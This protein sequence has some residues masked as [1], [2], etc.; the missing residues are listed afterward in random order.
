MQRMRLSALVLIGLLL[1]ACGS[2]NDDSSSFTSSAP[3]TKGTFKALVSF[4]DSL[5]DVG[6]YT[7]ATGALGAQGFGGKFTTNPGPVWTEAL[8]AKIGLSITPHQVGFN[9][10]SV[11]CPAAAAGAAAAATC[12][13]HSQGGARVTDPAGIGH[14]P[15]GTGALTV[16]MKQQIA[17]HLA[18]FGKFTEN[19]LI[20]VWG[21]NNDGFTQFGTIGAKVAAGVPQGTA[22]AEGQA[23]MKLA[24]QELA[25]YVKT[26]ILAKGGKY[27]AVINLPDSSRAP[28]GAT[29]T[30]DQRFLLNGLVQVFNDW[31][32]IEL[33]GQPVQLF[34]SY[35]ANN[36]I[37]NNLSKYGFVNSTLAI[38]DIA[39]IAAVTQ[40]AVTDGSSLFCGAPA[41][42]ADGANVNTWL[43]ADNVHPSTGFHKVLA[44]I[45]YAKMQSYGWL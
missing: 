31:L 20:V 17:N 40:N 41:T 19:D 3:S 45:I 6:T 22:V 32:R 2:S 13:G 16:P 5:S 38:C 24:A 33:N 7:P 1:A 4:G 23:A 35:T 14:H 44:D 39:K 10:Q 37:F 12:T 11:T 9:G 43:F 28:L 29:L 34:D 30:A 8:A 15:D 18:R 26:E 25:G 42:L 21:G 36:D 27:V